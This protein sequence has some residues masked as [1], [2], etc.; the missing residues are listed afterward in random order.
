MNKKLLALLATSHRPPNHVTENCDSSGLSFDSILT[1]DKSCNNVNILLDPIS[2]VSNYQNELSLL[3]FNMKSINK[4]E[5][6]DSLHEFLSLPLHPHIVCVSEIRRKDDP[7]LN[8]FVEHYKFFHADFPAQMQ[9]N[10]RSLRLVK[11]SL[12][13]THRLI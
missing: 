8:I 5:N 9:K 12:K 13:L 3:H 6:F 7:L 1:N 2:T 11:I 4:Q 10:S